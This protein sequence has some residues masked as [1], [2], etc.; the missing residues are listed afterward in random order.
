MELIVRVPGSCGEV[1]QGFWQGRPFLVTCPIDRYS[2]VVV[3]PGTGRLVGGGAKA[4]RA[5][6]RWDRPIAGATAWLMIFS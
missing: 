2:T 4:R 6:A 3:R 1:M 5:L